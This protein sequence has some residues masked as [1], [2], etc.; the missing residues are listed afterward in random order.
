V[1]SGCLQPAHNNIIL[2]VLHL[3]DDQLLKL[4]TMSLLDQIISKGLQ[5]GFQEG[6]KELRFT[7]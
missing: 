2:S 6:M 5:Q 3:E 7:L 4:D 1:Q